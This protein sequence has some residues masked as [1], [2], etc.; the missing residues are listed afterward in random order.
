MLSINFLTS[1]TAI[2]AEEENLAGVDVDVDVDEGEILG[3]CWYYQNLLTS[4]S[5]IL[6]SLTVISLFID[7]LI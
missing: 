1:I 7:W 3:I 5:T 2:E 6:S 4:T